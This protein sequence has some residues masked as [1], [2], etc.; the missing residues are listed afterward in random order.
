M[1]CILD[2]S[3]CPPH[4]PI[5][6]VNNTWLNMKRTEQN[7]IYLPSV[8]K[9]FIILSAVIIQCSYQNK[10]RCYLTVQSSHW[11]N[12]KQA[13]MLWIKFDIL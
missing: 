7:N 10:T 8:R 9:P 2:N 11:P 6:C 13:E 3:L 5:I 1:E 12:D 4:T